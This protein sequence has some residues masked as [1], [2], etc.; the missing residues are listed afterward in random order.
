MAT[1]VAAWG[2]AVWDGLTLHKWGGYV[3]GFDQSAFAAEAWA[4]AYALLAIERAAVSS[5]IIIDN[6]AVQ[7]GV[8][9]ALSG[10]CNL[11]HC[12]GLRDI[13]PRVGSSGVA[14]TA[15]VPSHGKDSG[16]LPPQPHSAEEWRPLN[17]AADSIAVLHRDLAAEALRPWHFEYASKL[18]WAH[19]ALA[20]A[21][22]ALERY[23]RHIEFTFY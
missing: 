23:H 10:Q 6:A 22:A 19:G 20:A 5:L 9:T 11:Q 8:D 15:W 4:A 18:E 13:A 7:I 14:V 3:P 16:W 1:R 2:L 17:D 21:T 12:Q